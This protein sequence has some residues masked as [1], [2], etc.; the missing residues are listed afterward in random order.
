MPD[1]LYAVLPRGSGGADAGW[2]PSDPDDCCALP[3]TIEREPGGYKWLLHWN[4]HLRAAHGVVGEAARTLLLAALARMAPPYPPGAGEATV[5]KILAYD[6]ENPERIARG[7]RVHLLDA[8]PANADVPDWPDPPD[9]AAYHG[10]IGDIVRAVEAQ[11]RGRPGR[12]SWGRWWA[13]SGRPAAM[14]GPSIRGR[15]SGRTHRSCWWARRASGAGRAQPSTWGVRCSDWSIQSWTRCGS[16]ES[17]RAKPITGHLGR[18]EG[19]PR[20]LLVE[21]EFGR[22]LTIMNREGS[23]L[24]AV[25]RNAWDGVPLG[26]ARARDESLIARHHVSLLGHVTPIELRQKLTEADAANGFANRILF[27]AVRRQR[28]IPFPDSPDELVKEY[29][30]PLRA[31]IDQRADPVGD[32]VRRRGA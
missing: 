17:R 15:S 13:C 8:S 20:V 29:V 27:L 24:S 4:A 22:L 10:V 28:L 3:E 6:Q 11:H 7:G 1:A 9:E 5:D 32:E 16:W 30:K 25:L 19:E 21:P 26:H 18:S 31:A 14:P 23:T 2:T 12:A